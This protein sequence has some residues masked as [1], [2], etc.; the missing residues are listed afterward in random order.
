MIKDELKIGAIYQ[1][2]WDERP[3]RV[4]GFDDIEV[5]YDCFLPQNNSWAFSGNIKKK[6]YFYRTSAL[7]FIKKSKPI[8]FSAI[9]EEELKVFSPD[10]P[11]RVCRS[12]EFSWNNFKLS[13]L[14]EFNKQSEN[15]TDTIQTDK[16]VLIPYGS[17]GGLKR[18]TS[19]SADNSKYFVASE[20]IWKAKQLQEAVNTDI[21]NG[22]G[23]YRLGFEKGLPSYYIGEYF[24]RAGLLQLA[25]NKT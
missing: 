16:L 19:L 24:D 4:I 12:N 18:G 7:L 17:K 15:L 25:D 8:D 20:L 21:S 11:I 3:V 23:I 2:E 6:C 22:I 9:T 5:F 1:T 13:A 10:L 14:N